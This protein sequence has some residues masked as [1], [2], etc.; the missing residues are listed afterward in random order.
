MNVLAGTLL[1]ASTLTLPQQQ[2]LV[3]PYFSPAPGETVSLDEEEVRNVGKRSHFHLRGY[4]TVT[5]P[6]GSCLLVQAHPERRDIKVCKKRR[7]PFLSGDL[8]DGGRVNWVISKPGTVANVPLSWKTP[9]RIAK[10]IPG[11]ERLATLSRNRLIL[12]CRGEKTKHTRK[13]TLTLPNDEFWVVHFPKKDVLVDQPE[14][15]PNL[16]LDSGFEGGLPKEGDIPKARPK[17]QFLIAKERAHEKEPVQTYWAVPRRNAFVMSASNFSTSDT[18]DGIRGTCRYR[19]KGAP[20]DPES[21]V[22]ECHDT[23]AFDV[24][25]LHLQCAKSILSN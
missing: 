24:L 15:V 14:A 13:V 4:I 19:L 7:I 1:A 5:P 16:Y 9:H 17:E 2:K 11:M 6:K 8:D 12:G 23:D 21:G 25:L 3:S 18:P 20:S 10:V 22:I